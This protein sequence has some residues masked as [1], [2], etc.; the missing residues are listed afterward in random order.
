MSLE[1]R[2][3]KHLQ[4]VDPGADFADRVLQRLSASPGASKTLAPAPRRAAPRWA[5]AASVLLAVG[6]GVLIH[7]Q[8]EHDRGAAAAQQLA[9]ALEVTSRELETLHQHLDRQRQE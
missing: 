6:A 8:R 7:Q 1:E 3:K 9:L 2:L 5:L 4:P